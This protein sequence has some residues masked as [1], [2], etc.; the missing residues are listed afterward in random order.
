MRL[1]PQARR[2]QLL[3]V[4]VGLFSAMPYEEVRMEDVALS[5]GVSR[6]LVYHY[7]PTKR[8]LFAA[9]YQRA[10]DRLVEASL[11]IP[12]LPVYDQV[13]AGLDAHFDFFETN[14][15]TVLVANRGALAG[16]PLIEGIISNQLGLLRQKMLDALG[17]EGKPRTLA[18]IALYGWLAFVRAVCVEWLADDLISRDEVRDMCW[19][20]LLGALGADFALSDQP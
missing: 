3:D 11:H 7:F 4:G 8:D 20:S 9:L 10:S 12:E 18:S 14:A 13:M 6:A 2:D 16:D 5:A 19:R 17:L 1:D 15:R